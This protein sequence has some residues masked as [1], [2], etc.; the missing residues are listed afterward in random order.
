LEPVLDQEL[1]GFVVEDQT[2]ALLVQSLADLAEFQVDDFAQVVLRQM[3]EHDD[4]VHAVEELGA[5]VLLDLLLDA[6]LHAVVGRRRRAS[7]SRRP[8][9]S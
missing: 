9:R 5:E 3:A 7:G 8:T 1:L 6:I 2:E 4:V